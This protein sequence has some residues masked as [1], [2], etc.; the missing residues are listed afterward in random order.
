[1]TK[2]QN[3]NMLMN[4]SQSIVLLKIQINELLTE[5]FIPNTKLIAILRYKL[6]MRQDSFQRGKYL[7][8]LYSE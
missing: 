8:V 2:L 1:M 5:L 4:T 6:I 7:H 3:H